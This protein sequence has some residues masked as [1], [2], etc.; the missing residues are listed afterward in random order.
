MSNDENKTIKAYYKGLRA[1][2]VQQNINTVKMSVFMLN[3]T[4]DIPQL[5]NC[6]STANIK[7]SVSNCKAS[8]QECHRCYIYRNFHLQNA[9]FPNTADFFKSNA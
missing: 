5:K 1:S 3:L 8:L 4:Q 6:K 7:E 2:A 9:W